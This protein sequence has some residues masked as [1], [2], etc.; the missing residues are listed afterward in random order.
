MYIPNSFRIEDAEEIETIIR[1]NGFGIL[2]TTHDEHPLATHLPFFY[3]TEHHALFA[4]M[5]RANPQWQ[6]LEG[7]SVLV[8]FS[9]PHAYISPSWYELPQMVPTWNYTAVHVY[10]RARVINDKDVLAQIMTKLVQVYD[11]QSPLSQQTQDFFYQDL[12]EG[13][14]GFRVDIT[15][16]QA[17]AKLSQNRSGDVRRRIVKKLQERGTEADHQVA[18][19]M[20]EKLDGNEKRW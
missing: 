10:G 4:H 11:P 8:I 17:A 20:T 15:R 7:Q 14:V 3:D 13:I 1:N 6:N 12:M 2:V 19:A 5:A 16:V 9:G 18:Q